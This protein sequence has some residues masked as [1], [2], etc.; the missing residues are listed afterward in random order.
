MKTKS[1]K[2]RATITT[3]GVSYGETPLE[4]HFEKCLTSKPIHFEETFVRSDPFTMKPSFE[5]TSFEVAVCW[6]DLFRK[7]LF[8]K[9]PIL[10]SWISESGGHFARCATSKSIVFRSDPFSNK[11]IFKVTLLRKFS[12]SRLSFSK[13]LFLELT[14]FRSHRFWSYHNSNCSIPHW[15]TFEVTYFWKTISKCLIKK[16]LTSK[17]ILFRSSPFTKMPKFDVTFSKWPIF[18]K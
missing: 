7:D 8:A 6:N 2:I 14:F 5:I 9:W 13:W 11:L 12:F 16:F 15:P 10:N 17:W 1:K 18:E 4:G 3:N